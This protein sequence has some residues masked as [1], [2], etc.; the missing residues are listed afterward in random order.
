MSFLA[1]VFVVYSLQILLLLYFHY[2]WSVSISEKSYN[3]VCISD[4]EKIKEILLLISVEKKHFTVISYK[5]VYIN[6]ISKLKTRKFAHNLGS[7]EVFHSN[8]Q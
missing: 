6:K 4:H 2:W 3:L 8:S 1:F 5:V 7:K